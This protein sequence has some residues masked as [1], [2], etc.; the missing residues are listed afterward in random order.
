GPRPSASPGRSRARS[1]VGAVAGTVTG[2]SGTQVTV[3]PTSGSP[4]TLTVPTTVRVSEVEPAGAAALQPDQCVRATGNRDSRG[5]VQAT[6]VTVSPPGP[7]GSC[8]GGFGG[9]FGGGQQGARP[10][11]APS[12]RTTGG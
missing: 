10:S 9:G 2:V 4:S 5:A 6:S 7:S 3:Q 11:P 12:A 1:G 8:T